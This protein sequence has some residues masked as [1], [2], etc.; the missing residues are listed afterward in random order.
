MG[1]LHH[2]EEVFG[3]WAR[4]PKKTKRAVPQVRRSW[5]LLL[6]LFAQT[7]RQIQKIQVSLT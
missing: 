7:V 4:Q 5:V 2:F 1:D 3:E 6:F